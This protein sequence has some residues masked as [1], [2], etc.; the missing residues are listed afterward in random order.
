MIIDDIVYYTSH[1]CAYH[2]SCDCGY[3]RQKIKLRFLLPMF[4]CLFFVRHA[5]E[6]QS[7]WT[8]YHHEEVGVGLA[9]YIYC[10][11]ANF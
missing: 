4:F 6:R 10:S 8:P 2:A 1:N 7:L 3:D 5:F 9:N 11:N